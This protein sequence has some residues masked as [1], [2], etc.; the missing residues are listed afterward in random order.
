MVGPLIADIH[1]D[2]ID[3]W[4]KEAVAGGAKVLCGVTVHDKANNT[5]LP[6]LLTNTINSMKVCSEEV[7]GP[8]AIIE[9]VDS[10]D[11]CNEWRLGDLMDFFLLPL[12]SVLP[13][14]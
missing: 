5:Y 3:N 14:N 11:D 8:I 9:S 10:F 4:V 7:F 6:T 13:K 2:R 1:L 12:L